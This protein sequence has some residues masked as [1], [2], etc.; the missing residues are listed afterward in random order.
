MVGVGYI[1]GN[2]NTVNYKITAITILKK[3]NSISRSLIFDSKTMT[4]LLDGLIRVKDN[5]NLH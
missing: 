2:G 1:E 5:D 4:T 3:E